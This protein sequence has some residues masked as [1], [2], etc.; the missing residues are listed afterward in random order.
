[1]MQ[2]H[3]IANA[4]LISAFWESTRDYLEEVPGSGVCET[5]CICHGFMLN[6]AFNISTEMLRKGKPPANPSVN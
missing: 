6:G 1:M 5:D 4:L 2:A 3:P